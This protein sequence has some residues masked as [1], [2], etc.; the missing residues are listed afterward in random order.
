MNTASHDRE[1]NERGSLL[2][3]WLLNLFGYDGLLPALIFFLPGLVVLTLGRGGWLEFV[4][5]VLPIVAFLIRSGVGLH[6]IE[7]HLCHP[8][9]RGFQK[10]ALFIGLLLLLVVDAFIILSWIVPANALQREDFII[11]AWIYASYLLCMA[12]A[13]YPGRRSRKRNFVP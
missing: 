10:L 3:Q 8:V 9:L 4:A 12:F 6:Q 11:E 7:R 13:S 1:P 5:V 2:T